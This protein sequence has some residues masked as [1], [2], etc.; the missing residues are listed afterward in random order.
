MTTSS[1]DPEER[2]RKNLAL[3]FQRLSSVGQVRVAEALQVSE[4]AVSKMKS[5]DLELFAKVLAHLGIK[6]VPDYVKCYEPKQMEA[7]LALAKARLA[8]IENCDELAWEE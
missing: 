1:V 3:I 7:I 8:D 2:A 4:S 6:C 5:G